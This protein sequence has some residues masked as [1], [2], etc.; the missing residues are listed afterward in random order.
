MYIYIPNLDSN[1]STVS[2]VY[3]VT[4]CN[5]GWSLM[6][7]YIPNLDSNTNTVYLVY[8]VTKC[9]DG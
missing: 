7:I 5:D 3:F 4:K 2:L 9:K 8:F 6:Y 1:K